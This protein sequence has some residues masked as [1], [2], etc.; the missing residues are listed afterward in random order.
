MPRLLNPPPP[1]T[2]R[3]LDRAPSGTGRRPVALTRRCS[4]E[5]PLPLP[6]DIGRGGAGGCVVDV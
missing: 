6:C 1:P 2:P 3:E 4:T 5:P